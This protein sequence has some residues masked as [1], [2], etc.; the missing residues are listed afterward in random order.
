VDAPMLRGA[1]SAEACRISFRISELHP[2]ILLRNQL[3][4]QPL[5]LRGL[6]VLS[7]FEKGGVADVT[8]GEC[9]AR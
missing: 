8:E 3:L 5:V 6:E 2:V 9:R 1:D 7:L 4:L